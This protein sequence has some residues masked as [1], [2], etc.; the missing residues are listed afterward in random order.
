MRNS[1]WAGEMLIG[2]PRV[3]PNLNLLP[4]AERV[5]GKQYR[6]SLIYTLLFAM[7]MMS[8]QIVVTS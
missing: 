3:A 7:Q 1:Y 2:R 8:A 4:R 6:P 5:S